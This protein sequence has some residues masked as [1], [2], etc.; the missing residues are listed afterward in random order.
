MDRGREMLWAVVLVLSMLT[1]IDH[2]AGDGG[3]V[4]DTTPQSSTS[5]PGNTDTATKLGYDGSSS[6]APPQSSINKFYVWTKHPEKYNSTG[7]RLKN[8]TFLVISGKRANTQCS[9]ECLKLTPCLSYNFDQ[10]AGTCELNNATHLTY[11]GDFVDSTTQEYHTREAYSIDKEAL[12]PCYGD[13][14]NSRGRCLETRAATGGLIPIC[15]C[16]DGWKGTACDVRDPGLQW[17]TWGD[18]SSCSATCE[19]GWK[20]RT[21][22]CEDA[23]TQ[24]TINPT[25]C[26]GAAQEYGIC[27]LQSCP[28]W[29]PWG[30]WGDC[31]TQ[32]TCGQGIQV[33]R[34]T[35]TNGGTIGVDRYCLGMS[36]QTTPCYGIVCRGPISIINGTYPGEGRVEFYNDINKNWSQICA[37]Q[38]TDYIANLICRQARWAG[39][40]A[41]IKDARFG[42]GTGRFGLTSIKC[43]GTEKNFA[44]CSHNVLNATN[45]RCSDNSMVPGGVQ[46]NVDGVWSLWSS[47]SDCTVSCENGTRTRTRQCS[48]PRPMYGGLPC[49]GND[50][51][52]MVC[53]SPPCPMPTTP[54]EPSDGQWLQWG[55]WS[56][57]SLTCGS[58]QQRRVRQCQQ[59]LNGGAQCNGQGEETR[60]CNQ[61]SCP[62]DGVWSTWSNWSDCSVTCGNGSQSRTRSCSGPYYGGTPCQGA[63][64]ETQMCRPKNCPVDG[65]WM[66]W[67]NWSQCS[68]SCGGG[69]RVRHRECYLGLYGGKNCTGSGS[70]QSSCNDNQCPVDGTWLP[71]TEWESCS[72]SCGSGS[73]ARYRECQGPFYGG[74]NCT[75]LTKEERSCNIQNCSVDGVWALWSEWNQ[76]SV[77]CG[78]GLQV[79]QRD[80]I[81]PFFGGHNCSGNWSDTKTC[82]SSNCPVDG[83]LTPWT[84]WGSC[85]ISCGVGYKIRRRYCVAPLNGGRPCNGSLEEN[86]ICNFKDCPVNGVLMNWGEWSE[87][88]KTCNGGIIWRN[89]TCYG[90]F[91]GGDDCPGALN[92]TK[93]CNEESCPVDG[94]WL[95]WTTWSTCSVS[96]GNG[97]Q[98]RTRNCNGPFY[99]GKICDGENNQTSQCFTGEC[100]VDGVFGSWSEWSGCSKTCGAGIQWRSRICTGPFY[101]GKDC[102]GDRNQTQSCNT[103]NCPVDG[104][105]NSW[106]VWSTCSASC[107][108]GNQ[109]R[110]RICVQPLYGGLPCQGSNN[111][112]QNCNEKHCPVDGY[113]TSWSQ[114]STCTAT[115]G[116]GTQWRNR[117]CIPPQYDGLDC[118]GDAN[119]TQPCNTQPCPIDGV[120]LS[121]SAWS[122]C[123][124][125]CGGG[126]RER[127][128]LCVE[129]KY[130]GKACVG[131]RAEYMQ[132]SDNPCPIPG[133]WFPWTSWTP[134]T[135][136][137]NGGT[138]F[139]TRRCNTTAYGDLTAPC[140]GAA[141]QSAVCHTFACLPY[142]KTCSEL[143]QRGLVDSTHCEIDP[144]GPE[145]FSLEPVV[146]YCNMTAHNGSGVTVIGHN[147]EQRTQVQGWE[148]ACEYQA[149]LVYN[150][151]FDHA[152]A[153]VDRSLYCEQFIKWECFAALIHNYNDNNKITTGWLNR[154]KGLADYFGGAPP[155]SNFCEC[156]VTHSCAEYKYVC[157]CDSNDQVWRSDQGYLTY[158]DDLPVYA[159]VAGDTGDLLTEMGYFSLGPIQCYGN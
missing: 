44:E 85:N 17:T 8:H 105:Y 35:C 109:T 3:A 39:G 31:S 136:T 53:S 104:Y 88:S 79:R 19:K 33:R 125:T 47:W 101:G 40:H 155:G 65:Q 94:V 150:V 78:S 30:E 50:T 117:T 61:Q 23:A 2:S 25:L 130:G 142:A 140:I 148:G 108:G 81:G 100:P 123:N 107:G 87:C 69:T 21:R 103:F 45:G 37:N 10:T 63:A 26:Y 70:E 55:S 92:E 7:K 121:W 128:R 49:P 28:R 127:T 68:V 129:P 146:V 75:G 14:C 134:C 120:W 141:N 84:T 114:W 12:G 74:A 145:Q 72:K 24:Q 116:G 41:A 143:G 9:L 73:Q 137:C 135:V 90:P 77:T 5:D 38:M 60:I 122:S 56:Q 36:N 66:D 158:K 1:N 159:F 97:V 112:T 139:R 22:V 93:P 58:G 16:D 91:Y 42:M 4:V 52:I 18:W 83:I 34:R 144:D 133:I 126:L 110:N 48:E 154:T 27:E 124:T 131:E 138:R 86:S 71:W 11:P 15:L 82:S 29:S 99:G 6:T 115:C 57:C 51:E 20:L 119:T 54:V 59:P 113:F 106:S 102:Q 62:I 76:C 13:P 157:N 153:I 80:C 96:C 147:Q 95:A 43:N 156:G 111:E 46:C 67:E 64:N 32:T 149:V 98:K 118:S 89:R 132:C 152:V 151:S